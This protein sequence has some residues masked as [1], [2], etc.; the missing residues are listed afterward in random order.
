MRT[1][2]LVVA[3]LLGAGLTTGAGPGTAGDRPLHDIT[4]IVNP[5]PAVR[6][7]FGN[8]ELE[9][10]R[11]Q[12]GLRTAE[13]DYSTAPAEAEAGTDYG[14]KSGTLTL[15]PVDTQQVFVNVMD[16]T[17]EEAP[18]TFRFQLDEARGGTVLRFPTVATITIV[19]N[20]GPG[21]VSF[22]TDT[23]SSYENRGSFL[24]TLVRSGADV[25]G[26]ATVTVTSASGTAESGA[27]FEEVAQTVVTF[28]ANE[29]RKT[30]LVR[31]LNDTNAEETET[32]TVSLSS[33][34]GAEVVDPTSATVEILDDDSG[35]SDSVPPVSRFHLPRD[36]RTYRASLA[37]EIHL[38][39]SDDASGV[40]KMWVAL[41]K[42]MRSGKCAW[43]TGRR[44]RRGSCSSKRWIDLGRVPQ[45]DFDIYRLSRKLKPTTR[46]TGIAAYR[47][48]G[49]ARDQ[50]GNAERRF[51]K[52]RNANTYKI[53]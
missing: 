36:G 26:E 24:V 16:D 5:S 38:F 1:K 9:V 20:D 15:E 50:A 52:G 48:F 29:F 31:V 30:V 47:V 51:D 33:P 46:K 45:N 7:G 18:E 19:D 28:A 40:A 22:A 37:R 10:R 12:H 27:D 34:S 17:S 4:Y 3:V 21:R 41:K 8:V 39:S 2:R 14:S 43:W 23:Y 25:S 53:K 11:L 49:R 32:F 35:T 13:V 44:F 6:E 42:K